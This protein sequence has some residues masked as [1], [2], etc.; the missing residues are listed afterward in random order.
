M[1]FALIKIPAGVSHY[2]LKKDNIKNLKCSF[3]MF[4]L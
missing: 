1:L 4:K 3:R 2:Y